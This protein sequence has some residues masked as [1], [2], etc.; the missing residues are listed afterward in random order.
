LVGDSL[1]EEAAPYLQRLLGGKAFVP[2]FFAGTAPCDWLGK[3][4]QATETSIVV[5]S[6]TGNSRTPCMS[7]GAGGYLHGQALVDKYRADIGALIAEARSAGAHALLV[8]QPTRA[9]VVAGNDEVQ[10]INHVYTDLADASGISFVD[11]GAAVETADGSYAERLAC[12]PGEAECAASGSN[13]MRN[14]DGLHF[15]PGPPTPGP[16]PVYSSGAFRFASAIA[17]AVNAL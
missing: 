9:S 11:A 10:G 6:F 15:C 16:C 8:G 14:D 7:D 3:D 13:D 5:I 17:V 1:A 2:Q 12:L 4:L